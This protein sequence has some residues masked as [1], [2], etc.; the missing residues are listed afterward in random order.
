MCTSLHNIVCTHCSKELKQLAK[1]GFKVA[2]PSPASRV[3]S[4]VCVGV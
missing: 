3:V 4:V 2:L 1:E